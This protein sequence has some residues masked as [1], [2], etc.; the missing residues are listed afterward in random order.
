MG[1]TY[2]HTQHT[3]LKEETPTPRFSY[4]QDRAA[5]KGTH[6]YIFRADKG[7]GLTEFEEKVEYYKASNIDNIQW[8]GQTKILANGTY[9]HDIEFKGEMIVR[10]VVD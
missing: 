5:G 10:C 6:K 3:I 2:N 4:D 9:V 1:N 7:Y 8:D